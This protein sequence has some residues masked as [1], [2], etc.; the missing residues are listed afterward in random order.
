MSYPVSEEVTPGV[1]PART[2]FYHISL[3]I[4][5]PLRSFSGCGTTVSLFLRPFLLFV[6][7]FPV[8]FVPVPATEC[9]H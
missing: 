3:S 8:V 2:P 4:S 7:Q 9:G 5:R 1:S 6:S